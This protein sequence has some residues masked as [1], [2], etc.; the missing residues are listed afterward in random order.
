MA[1]KI[2]PSIVSAPLNCLEKLIKEL[3]DSRVSYIHFDIEDGQFVQS[4]N[5]GVKIISDLR[6]LTMLPFDVHLMMFNPEWLIEDLI[7]LG[8]NRIAVHYEACLY[9]RRILRRIVE[10]GAVAGLAFN[11]ATAL[12]DLRYLLPFL[13]FVVILTTEPESQDAPFLPEVLGK[14]NSAKQFT[15]L[16]KIE[17][18]VDGGI[19]PENL[20]MVLKAGAETVVVGRSIFRRGRI[21]Q[22]VEALRAV[23][24]QNNKNVNAT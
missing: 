16:K 6:P 21:K 1:L 5:L 10:L 17:W 20:N 18:V 14:I 24:K 7:R 11:P 12:P 22:N 9:P 23:L 19:C 3:E 4:M 2:A 13:S 15:Q 8:A